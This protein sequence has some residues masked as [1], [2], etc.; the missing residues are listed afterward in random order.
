[1]GNQCC[2]DNQNDKDPVSFGMQEKAST[3]N[4]DRLHSRETN[5]HA[6]TNFNEFGPDTKKAAKV[7][8][9]NKKTKIVNKTLAKLEL[10]IENFQRSI[11]LFFYF[12]IK[13]KL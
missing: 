1:M 5:S 8:E 13:R 10:G 4:K 12:W 6:S 3:P 2:A 11:L 9:M 7:S